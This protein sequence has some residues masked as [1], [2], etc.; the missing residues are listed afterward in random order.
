[1]TKTLIRWVVLALGA[2]A[3]VA[4]LTNALTSDRG[5]DPVTDIGA[6]ITWAG[7]DPINAFVM[8]V[9]A[10]MAGIGAWGAIVG[11]LKPPAA[12]RSDLEA[13]SA[14][15]EEVVRSAADQA[16]ER[17]ADLS[18]SI[19]RIAQKL[20]A[21][22]PE[23]ASEDAKKNAEEETVSLLQEIAGVQ[24]FDRGALRQAIRQGK[25][26]SL[27]DQLMA[28]T[29]ADRREHFL[30]AERLAW[31]FDNSLRL[32]ALTAAAAVDPDDYELQRLIAALSRT[33]AERLSAI[34]HAAVLADEGPAELK[35]RR[36]ISLSRMSDL[37]WPMR[38]SFAN[39]AIAAARTPPE[40]AEGLANLVYVANR[41][42][43]ASVANGAQFERLRILEDLSR[44][45]PEDV[46][47][48]KA[49][50]EAYRDESERSEE[51]G[52]L[53]KSHEADL[54]SL[55]VFERAMQ[56]AP[57]NG[58]VI[59][60]LIIAVERLGEWFER[61]ED[62]VKARSHFE[63]CVD[64]QVYKIE[65]LGQSENSFRGLAHSCRR[66][67]LFLKGQGDLKGAMEAMWRAVQ[68]KAEVVRLNKSD[69]H[70]SGVAGLG[71]TRADLVKL[72]VAS[73]DMQAA[74][75][76]AASSITELQHGLAEGADAKIR[77]VLAE[78]RCDFA[79]A[80]ESLG[81]LA[82][83]KGQYAAA[84]HDAEMSIIL[85]RQTEQELLEE[86]LELELDDDGARAA[87][88]NARAAWSKMRKE[89]EAISARAARGAEQAGGKLQ[90]G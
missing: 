41:A 86:D 80:L 78:V 23:A 32:P 27:Y 37:E 8:L 53:S 33:E 90:T 49:L 61:K 82:A 63:R 42:S 44:A 76:E 71:W 25:L 20:A 29:G 30:L 77:L 75:I 16:A 2:A 21:D 31:R 14:R 84:A 67:S 64:L 3:F 47:V 81:E 35:Q 24:S 39:A 46:D 7:R 68:A 60:D 36:F 85:C 74:Q 51:A 6:W 59:A 38:E 69:F 87:W 40:R 5:P 56:V 15:T 79:V 72:L 52:D 57:D 10:F 73:G 22:A 9:S 54:S 66:L 58:E 26:R 62:F 11:F 43:Q 48:L 89:A 45:S 28:S 88:S 17:D 83:A 50:G 1:M 13:A 70:Y 18:E 12:S 55:R 65:T 4:L 19:A 34:Q